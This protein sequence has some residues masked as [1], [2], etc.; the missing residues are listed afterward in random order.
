MLFYWSALLIAVCANVAANVA[1]KTAMRDLPAPLNPGAFAALIAAPWMWA[2]MISAILLLACFLIA[3]RGI[4]LSIAYPAV[5][6]LAT[7][8]VVLAGYILF[9]ESL[10]VLKIAG[11][12]FVFLGIAMLAQ[13]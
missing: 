10:S 12:G 4:D 9:A 8:G 3:L 6:G 7:V 2:G 11:V 5:T 1:F 13:S